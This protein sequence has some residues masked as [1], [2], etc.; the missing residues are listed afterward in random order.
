MALPSGIKTGK[1]TFGQAVSLVGGHPTSMTFTV[2]PTHDLVHRESGIQLLDFS[3]TIQVDEDM[4]GSITLPFTDQDGFVDASG[5]A[6]KG[7]A[8]RVQGNWRR[9]SSSKPF[10]KNF[11]L[12]TGQDEID[13]DLIPGGS[14]SL[15]VTAPVATVTSFL[16]KTGAITEDDLAELDLGGGLTEEQIAAAATAPGAPIKAALDGTYATLD[17]AAGLSEVVDT[18]A[19]AQATSDALAA[20]V[21]KTAADA[22]YA[23]IASYAANPD[24]MAV[25]PITRSA[26]GAATSFAVVWPNGATGMFTGTES[27]TAPGAIDSYTVT[28]VVGATTTTYTQPALTRDDSGAVTARPGITVS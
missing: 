20:R 9:G 12:L 13:F 26:S 23:S 6:F 25:G 22:A 28:H 5:N 4:P 19:D 10:S 27:T 24:T 16:S 14:I 3:E 18:K 2:T 7:W 17:A 21:T 11:Q 15:P 1:V 8:Y